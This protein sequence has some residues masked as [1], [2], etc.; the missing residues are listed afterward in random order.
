MMYATTTRRIRFLDTSMHR[1]ATVK[2][3]AKMYYVNNNCGLGWG[4]YPKAD[5]TPL[6]V[7]RDQC[8]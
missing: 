7:I 6:V 4:E 5:W 8:L 3:D 1:V 2:A